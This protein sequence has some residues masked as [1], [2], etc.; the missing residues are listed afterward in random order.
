MDHLIFL[1]AEKPATVTCGLL[2]TTQITYPSTTSGGKTSEDSCDVSK[3]YE[4]IK[5][6]C[7]QSETDKTD[8]Y[9]MTLDATTDTTKITIKKDGWYKVSITAYLKSDNRASR[10]DVFRV[11]TAKKLLNTCVVDSSREPCYAILQLR[12][13]DDVSEVTNGIRSLNIFNL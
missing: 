4:Y 2:G 1:F 11:S 7:T 9:Y 6:S 5:W 12:A 13:D 8:Q 10:V 3:N